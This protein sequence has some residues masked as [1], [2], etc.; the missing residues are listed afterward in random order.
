MTGKAESYRSGKIRKHPRVPLF[1]DAGKFEDINILVPAFKHKKESNLLAFVGNRMLKNICIQNSERSHGLIETLN[2]KVPFLPT[3]HFDII[4]RLQKCQ[5]SKQ[6]N[7][8][9]C[10]QTLSGWPSGVLILV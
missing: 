5:K 8:L 9:Y 2:R 1:C 7:T 4:T 3:T 6:L 10:S